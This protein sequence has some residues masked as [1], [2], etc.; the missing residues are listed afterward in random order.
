MTHSPFMPE[1]GVTILV[2]LIFF[3]VI[4]EILVH[5]HK[6]KLQKFMISTILTLIVAFIF[7]VIHRLEVVF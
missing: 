4:Y 6:E 3:L 1:L 7:L 5:Q 2:L